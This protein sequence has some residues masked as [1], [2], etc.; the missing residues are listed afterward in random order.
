VSYVKYCYAECHY[1]E[2]LILFIVSHF[3]YFYA[4]C[5]YA[6]SH[7]AGCRYAV[8]R[9]AERYG[10]GHIFYLSTINRLIGRMFVNLYFSLLAAKLALCGYKLKTE[11]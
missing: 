7:Y 2:F 3:I 6:Q 1:A 9:Y 5:H 11:K 10:S 8:Y 4:E